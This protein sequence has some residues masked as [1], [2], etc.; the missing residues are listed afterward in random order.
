MHLVNLDADE[1]VTRLWQGAY[2]VD[3]EHR[4]HECF[5]AVVFCCAAGCLQ[6]PASMFGKGIEVLRIY[7]YDMKDTEVPADTASAMRAMAAE[8]ARRVEAGKRVLVTCQAGLN[9]SGVIVALA[10]RAM[11]RPAREC[12][13]LVRTRRRRRGSQLA[14]F[15]RAFVR[16]IMADPA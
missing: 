16:F 10:L 5:D 9:R 12:I 6:P 8:V 1:I 4:L 11:G 14:L 7:L 15:N 3:H 2:P 13:R